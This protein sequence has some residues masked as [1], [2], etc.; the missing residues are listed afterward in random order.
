MVA[1]WSGDHSPGRRC[2]TVG[3]PAMTM[4]PSSSS[5][6]AQTSARRTP[7]LS[8]TKP[9]NSMAMVMPPVSTATM[10]CA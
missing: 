3:A 9:R 2:R 4:R 10:L 1:R 8:G 6:N 5:T 7:T